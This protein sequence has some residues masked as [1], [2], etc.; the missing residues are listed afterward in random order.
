MTYERA[1]QE[2]GRHDIRRSLARGISITR[3][4]T[5]PLE[6]VYAK[7]AVLQE[8]YPS[9]EVRKPGDMSRRA[10]A[11][12]QIG[13][14]EIWS[15]REKIGHVAADVALSAIFERVPSLSA[16]QP[17]TATWVD[18]LVDQRTKATFVS[19][20][21]TAKDALKLGRERHR[22]LAVIEDLAQGEELEWQARLPDIAMAYVPADASPAALVD[23]IALLESVMPL[24]VTLLPPP[25][26]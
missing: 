21:P 17:I 4:M 25:K 10:P 1:E 12:Q 24:S 7:F 15:N 26:V 20:V 22:I 8:Y 14:K 5:G 3:R 13:S 19:I 18:T 9:L 2:T 16:D 6:D 11:L 23:T